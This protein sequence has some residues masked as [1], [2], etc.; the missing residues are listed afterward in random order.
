MTFIRPH[1]LEREKDFIA[2]IFTFVAIKMVIWMIANY[3]TNNESCPRDFEPCI[4]VT[5]KSSV[6]VFIAQSLMV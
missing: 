5:C 6:G 4:V 3:I 2:Q 1:F